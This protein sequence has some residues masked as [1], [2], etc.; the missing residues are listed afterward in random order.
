[1]EEEL[2]KDFPGL[3]EQLNTTSDRRERTQL[4][5]QA[6]NS[7]ASVRMNFEQIEQFIKDARDLIAQKATLKDVATIREDANDKIQKFR[8]DVKGIKTN[9]QSVEQ[10]D[11]ES[12]SK[13]AEIDEWYHE[14]K[15]NLAGNNN[16]DALLWIG[17]GQAGGQILRECLTYCLQNLADAR[18]SA[19]LTALGITSDDK[20]TILYNMKLIH[21]GKQDLKAN[22]ENKLKEIF[23]KKAHVLAINL[24]K[25]STNWQTRLNRVISCE[26]DTHKADSTSQTV[27]TKRNI[28]KLI[29]DGKGAGGATGIGR[30]YGFRFHSDISEAMRDVGK[31]V[32][33]STTHCNHTQSIRWLWQWYG[34]SSA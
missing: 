1:M 33:P 17:L 16:R 32:I 21:S 14:L 10:L 27:R 20:K 18:C 29:E 5:D 4:I 3:F 9:N 26:G 15:S 24:E 31:R 8:S 2:K 6:Y 25:R 28:L 12:N 22:A 30:A 13:L 23:D 34:S 7:L 11:E 19:L